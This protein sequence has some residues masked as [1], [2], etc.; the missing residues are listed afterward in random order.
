VAEHFDQARVQVVDSKTT[1]M[2]TTSCIKQPWH[3]MHCNDTQF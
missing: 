2:R 1:P 3:V